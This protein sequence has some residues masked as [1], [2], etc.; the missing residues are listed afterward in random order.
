MYFKDENNGLHFLSDDDIANGGMEFLPFGCVEITNEEAEA[1]RAEKLAA[2]P[3][4]VPQEV[5]R[6]QALAALHLAGKLE[7]VEAIMTS[8][9]TDVLTKLAWNNAQ[10]F[11]R[12]SPMVLSMA[13]LLELTETDLDNLF[14][15]A[16]GIE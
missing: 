5:T 9:E 15:T 16:S 8:P 13:T 1:I 11:K 2:I 14:I 6:F 10:T 12:Q 3:V 7:Q 4:S